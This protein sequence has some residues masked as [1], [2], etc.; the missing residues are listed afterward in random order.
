MR[1]WGLLSLFRH[2]IRRNQRSQVSPVGVS[3]EKRVALEADLADERV[4]QATQDS[5]TR[6]RSIGQVCM[7]LPLAVIRGQ[8][9]TRSQTHKDVRTT[10]RLKLDPDVV[11][12][13][14]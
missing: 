11:V 6:L 10:H 8:R 9:R 12:G 13:V 3:R 2:L 1:T 14:L 4:N 7:A 5:P